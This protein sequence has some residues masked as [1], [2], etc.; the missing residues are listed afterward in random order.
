MFVSFAGLFREIKKW[1]STICVSAMYILPLC[2]SEFSMY[3][4]CSINIF[5][6]MTIPGKYLV[7]DFC[8]C[9]R[10]C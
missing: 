2:V 4:L 10:K 6:V 3:P 5:D 8:Y 1:V 7:P 9:S